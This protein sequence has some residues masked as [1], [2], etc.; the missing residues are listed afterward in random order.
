MLKNANDSFVHALNNMSQS[1][2]SISNAIARSM[3][4]FS[5][6]EPPRPMPLPYYGLEQQPVEQQQNGYIQL[7]PA[8]SLFYE[9]NQ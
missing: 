8:R 3:E 6:S 7:Q 2:L 1:I 9:G 4:T 5:N